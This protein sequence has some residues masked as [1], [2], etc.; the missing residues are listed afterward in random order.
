[1]LRQLGSPSKHGAADV[2]AMPP[3]S[4]DW[5]I[6]Q[7]WDAYTPQEHAVW[8]TLFQ[9]QTKLLPRRACDE[10]VRGMSELPIGAEAIPD[11][12]RLSDVLGKR[13]GWQ[14]IAVPGLEIGRAH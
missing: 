12:R 3:P 4:A 13:T 2:S 5:T 10:F 8:K 7:G 9:R 1:M 14:V 11:F 6:D